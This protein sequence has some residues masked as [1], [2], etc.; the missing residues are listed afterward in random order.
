MHSHKP[1]AVSFNL[2]CNSLMWSLLFLLHRRGITGLEKCNDLPRGTQLACDSVRLKPRS[3]WLSSWTSTGC[4]ASAGDALAGATAWRLNVPKGPCVIGLVSRVAILGDTSLEGGP[5]GEVL[6]HWG[7][8]WMGLCKPSLFPFRP[9][10]WLIIRTVSFFMCSSL[11]TSSALTR[12]PKQ[13]SYPVL[14]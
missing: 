4:S 6:G 11:S 10:S 2:C 5:L 14:D 13:W 9:A 7:V 3:V 8:P 1:G 12:G